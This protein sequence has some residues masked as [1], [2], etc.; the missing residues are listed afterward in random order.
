MYCCHL[1]I[2]NESTEEHVNM[3]ILIKHK[4]TRETWTL[5]VF[6]FSLGYDLC[7]VNQYISKLFENVGSLVYEEAAE[8]EKYN[9]IIT[10]VQSELGEKLEFQQVL[11]DYQSACY[12]NI[13]NFSCE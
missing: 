5:N 2:V 3:I 9:F 8:T 11:L 12:E 7:Q 13:Q 4:S 1:E 10:G 6:P